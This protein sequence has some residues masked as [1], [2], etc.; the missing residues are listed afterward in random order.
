MTATIR[1]RRAAATARR[2]Q[3]TNADAAGAPRRRGDATG[4]V[5]LK[6]RRAAALGRLHGGDP[7]RVRR[8]KPM[9]RV[10]PRIKPPTVE[11]GPPPRL[12]YGLLVTVAIL[13]M[14]GLVMVLSASSGTG[15]RNGSPY[16]VFSKQAVWALLGCAVALVVVKVPY[17]TWRAV[18]IPVA[19]L[20]SGAML[21]PFMPG[22]GATVN[23]A[24]S[25]VRVGGLSFQPSEF[26]KLAAIGFLAD[27]FA[28]HQHEVHDRRHGLIPMA[29]TAAVCAGAAAVQGDLGSAIVLAAIVLAI[30]VVAGIPLVHVATVAMAGSLAATAMIVSDPRRLHRLIAFRDIEGNKEDLAYQ[31]WQGLVSI[32]N[33]GITGTGVGGGNSKLGY[34]PLAHSDFIFA[35][36]AEELGFVGSVAVIGGFMLLVG[37]GVQAAL[38]APDRFGMLLAGGIAAWFGVQAIVNMGGVVGLMPVTGLTLPFFS[39]GGTSLFVSIVAAALLLNVARRAVTVPR[40]N[41]TRPIPRTRRLRRVGAMA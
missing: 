17:T 12:F 41:Q 21:L 4:T 39:A 14:L 31:S 13:V 1:E 15:V 20:A 2:R 37:L 40:A 10:V 11:L 6:E 30:G 28:R 7:R 27:Y 9:R 25:W 22:V 32:A 29:V 38:A 26:L 23:D 24:T 35:V 34:L 33:G 16:A 3:A 8:A 5:S 18:A 36:V 19:V